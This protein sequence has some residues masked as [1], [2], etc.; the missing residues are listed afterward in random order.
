MWGGSS[1]WVTSA[2]VFLSANETIVVFLSDCPETLVPNYPG[3]G[4]V[5]HAGHMP[6]RSSALRLALLVE[7]QLGQR[8]GTEDVNSALIFFWTVHS[9][10]SDAGEHLADYSKKLCCQNRLSLPSFTS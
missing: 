6:I 8:G 2:N 10:A 4:S 9:R 3:F 5:L 1:P 7:S